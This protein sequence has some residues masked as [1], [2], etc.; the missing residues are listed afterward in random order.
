MKRTV[1][2]GL[3]GLATVFGVVLVSIIIGMLWFDPARYQQQLEQR[4]STLTGRAF[5]IHGKLS[6]RLGS[7]VTVH[8]PQLRLANSSAFSINQ[9]FMEL[10]QA[11]VRIALWPL[12]RRQV[13]LGALDVQG[14]HVQLQRNVAGEDNW[15]DLLQLLNDDDGSGFK[16]VSLAGLQLHQA[17]FSYTDVS[18]DSELHLSTVTM[19]LGLF[20]YEQSTPV[21]LQG[22]LSVTPELQIN[23]QLSSVLQV[24]A[25]ASKLSANDTQVALHLIRS[26]TPMP[27]L[28]ASVKQVSW[29]RLTDQLHIQGTE[30]TTVAAQLTTEVTI[31]QL[32]TAPLLAA[33]IDVTVP[34]LQELA[35]QWHMTLPVTKDPTVLNAASAHLQLDTTSRAG[36][37]KISRLQLDDTRYQGEFTWSYPD[38]PTLTFNLH[39]DR[40]DLDRY[41]APV[42]DAPPQAVP[43]QWLQQLQARGSLTINDAWWRGIHA[44]QLTL[45]VGT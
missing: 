24:A 4:V 25:D 9:P 35:R 40:L 15:S 12:L 22:L 43:L 41:L 42:K 16:F 38:H 14:L 2:W 23:T 33:T 28:L 34:Q 11:T 21:S 29:D 18:N 17:Q 6:W 8:V 1:R 13:Q 3:W 19:Q 39:A 5:T 20:G 31:R 7:M 44:Q 37:M 10:S 36:Q 26:G 45:D 30:L 27:P 32:M